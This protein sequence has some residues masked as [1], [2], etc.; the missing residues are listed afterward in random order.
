MLPKEIVVLQGSPVITGTRYACD[1]LRCA[2]CGDQYVAEMPAE[3]LSQPKYDN[4]CRSAIAISRY[5]SG[6]PFKRLENLQ[7]L[8]GV[9]LADATQW[10]QVTQL[11]TCAL[12]VL[13]V[14]EK[15]AAQGQ[16]MYYDDTGNK[17]LAV[18]NATKA[19]HTTAFLS[20]LGR[21]CIYLFYTSQR[22]AGENMVLLIDERTTDETLITMTDASC[23]NIPKKIDDN[24]LS[25]W[26]L[27]FCL[28]HGRRKFYEVYF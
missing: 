22:Y 12:P 9:P 26:I 27:C 25:R 1:R 20:M 17:I 3:I 4:T 28:V 5:Y 13:S 6:M 11:Y 14:L 21:H 19:V 2:L 18:S 10:D 7:A 8:Q 16:L 23:Q 24:L 15:S